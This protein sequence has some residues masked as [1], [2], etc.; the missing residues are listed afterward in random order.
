[1]VIYEFKVKEFG[2]SIKDAKNSSA[3]APTI[4]KNISLNSEFNLNEVNGPYVMLIAFRTVKESIELINN[5]RLGSSVCLYSQNISLG[6]FDFLNFLTNFYFNFIFYDFILVMEV[7]YLLNVGTVWINSFPIE[8]GVQTRKQSGNY[9]I[10]GFRVKI[11]YIL[12][13]FNLINI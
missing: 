5:S 3:M 10:S 7:S 4:I 9:S 11:L 1:M 12:M 8:K 6:S 13:F 2:Q